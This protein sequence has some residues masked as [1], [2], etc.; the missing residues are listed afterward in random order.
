MST[1]LRTGTPAE[2][3]AV[4]LAIEGLQGAQGLNCM[5]WGATGSGKSAL[6]FE[7]AGRLGRQVVEFLLAVVEP[8]DIGG[9]P[10][11]GPDGVFERQVDARLEEAAL[12]G[13]LVLFDDFTSAPPAV[14]A[15]TLRA[16]LEREVAGLDLRGTPMVATATPGDGLQALLPAAA[17]RFL[18][19]SL[20]PGYGAIR[21]GAGSAPAIDLD[22]E[23]L[24]ARFGPQLGAAWRAFSPFPASATGAT[25]Q[26]PLPDRI[27]D[28]AAAAYPSAR[29][30][31]MAVRATAGCWAAGLEPAPLIEAAVGARA[32]KAL[33]DSWSRP[34]AR[35]GSGLRST[36]ERMRLRGDGGGSGASDA[37]YLAIAALVPGPRRGRGLPLV[38]WGGVGSGKSSLARAVLEQLGRQSRTIVLGTWLPTDLGGMPVP[39]PGRHSFLRQ[40]D[41]V[42]AEVSRPG[43]GLVLDDLTF[44]S[45]ATQNAALELVLSRRAGSLDLAATPMLVTANPASGG[46]LHELTPAMANRLLHF[47]MHGGEARRF[48]ENGGDVSVRLHFDPDLIDR[49]WETLHASARL[50]VRD[51]LERFPEWASRSPAAGFV[52]GG[53]DYAFPTPRSWEFAATVLAGCQAGGLPPLPLVAAAVGEEA[54][55]LLLQFD[56]SRPL[57]TPGEVFDGRVDWR[58][59]RPDEAISAV[60][61]AALAVRRPE[62]MEGLLREAR[63]CR[64]LGAA[65]IFA[66]AYRLLRERLVRSD[67]SMETLPSVRQ[68]VH[69][70]AAAL[71]P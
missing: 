45:P 34:V 49:R 53:L 12:P 4:A 23:R 51:F 9:L 70:L 37:D 60:T 6:A 7:V 5:L 2:Y 44:A 43:W 19:L 56:R 38:A 36:A 42:L 13:H 25:G 52:D 30:W 71:E 47:Q 29:S 62:E 10:I 22:V 32:A 50:L 16:V 68:G 61:A 41:P 31:E 48:L 65:D 55:A 46:A 28:A 26:A 27:E 54:A 18:H 66:P 67:L 39:A 64:E 59:L 8:E 1:R 3:L 14:Q 63:R 11:P 24:R 17:N 69:E 20:E 21:L 35:L 33:R 57:P 15:A 40:V 58:A